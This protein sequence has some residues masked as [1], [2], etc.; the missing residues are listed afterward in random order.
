MIGLHQGRWRC[1]AGHIYLSHHQ[2]KPTIGWFLSWFQFVRSNLA[3]LKTPRFFPT[4]SNRRVTTTAV[5][6]SPQFVANDLGGACSHWINWDNWDDDGSNLW[7]QWEESPVIFTRRKVRT[8][9]NCTESTWSCQWKKR[10]VMSCFRLWLLGKN[11]QQKTS[12]TCQ[13][14]NGLH[15]ADRNGAS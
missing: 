2:R 6:C 8:G 13:Y 3:P 10:A 11:Q 12:V 9:G 7:K 1:I 4:A 5:R 15:T 14:L